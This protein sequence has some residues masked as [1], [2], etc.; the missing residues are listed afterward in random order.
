VHHQQADAHRDERRCHVRIDCLD[1][2]QFRQ[3]LP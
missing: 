2:G 1:A 3:R